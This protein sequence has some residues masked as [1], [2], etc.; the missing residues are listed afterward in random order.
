MQI[1][2]TGGTGF[3][4]QGLTRS[5]LERG[6]KVTALV[7]R[8]ESPTA[9]RLAEIGAR[10]VA[11]DVTDRASM[12]AGMAGA[13]LVLHNA[14]AY[15]LG[16]TAAA[17]ERLT[18][19][20]L[21]GTANTLG[22]ALELGVPRTL[23]VST[24]LAFGD[25]GRIERDETFERQAPCRTHYELTKTEAHH[26]A[27][28]LRE[29]GLGLITVCPGGVIGV[30]DHSSWGYFLR[31]YINGWMP[32]VA[33]SPETIFAFVDVR[34]L[35]E[36]IVLAA[37]KG[38]LGETYL[39]TGEAATLRQTLAYWQSRPGRFRVWMWLPPGLAGLSMAPLEPVQRWLGLPAFLSRETVATG[40]TDLYHSSAKAQRELGWSH[41]SARQM[42]E[43]AL[44]G[45]L[46]LLRERRGE[47][48]LA[49]LKPRD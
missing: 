25:T 46:E 41:R 15:E 11:G 14:G 4:G 3:I 17:K 26:I 32:P 45:E 38:R 47:S 18:A 31:L 5:L 30:N 48:L 12:R 44:D 39:F 36:G 16:L 27:Q 7:R 29:K 13:D 33:W 34:D 23:Y 28:A 10:L 6:W 40:C 22:L 2:L 9:R 35:V 42:W 43:D 8:P 24:V 1:F 49:R 20:N 21:T 19:I 37:E